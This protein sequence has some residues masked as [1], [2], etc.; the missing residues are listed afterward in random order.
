MNRTAF[1]IDGFNLY[2]SVREASLALRGASTKWLDIRSLCTSYL[3][4]LGGGATLE[5]VH[6]FSALAKHLEATNPQ[7]TKRHRDLLECLRDDGVHIEL[8][9]FK[10]KT[11]R[12]DS[13]GHAVVR[14]EEKETDVAIAAKLLE[15]LHRDAIDSAV[16]M[17]G[18][19]DLAPAV[20]TAK[21]LFPIK[22][23]AFAFPYGRK[24][25]ELSQIADVAFQIT[26]EQY[27]RHQLPNP[28]VLRSGRAIAKPT[29]W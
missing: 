4:V 28:Y 13:C 6:Y 10:K 3:H 9:R 7:V 23:I 29:K 2:H 5:S 16:L 24:N 8:A 19:T 25:K 20:R 1:L 17:S 27:A 12:C 11:L 26:K 15:L 21:L 14:R 18:D 22:T